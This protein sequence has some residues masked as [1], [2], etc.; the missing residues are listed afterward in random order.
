MWPEALLVASA[1]V[2]WSGL[3]TPFAAQMYRDGDVERRI[4]LASARPTAWKAHSLLFGGGALLLGIGLGALAS[5][6]DGPWARAAGAV[7]A[8]AGL[9]G[10]SFA[11]RRSATPTRTWFTSRRGGAHFLAFSVAALGAFALLGV[12]ALEATRWLGIF[13]L[14]WTGLLVAVLLWL[15]DL[16]PFTHWVGALVW[17]LTRLL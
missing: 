10:A 9:L 6:D 2:A 4:R 1:A 5:T 11:L 16:P 14:A 13:L 3:L 17:A 15:R 7:G 12:E 8:T